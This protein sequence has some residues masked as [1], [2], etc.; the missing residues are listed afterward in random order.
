MNKSAMDLFAQA[1]KDY[2]HGDSAPLYFTVSN[3]RL[4]KEI[5]RYFRECYQL[6]NLEKKLISLAKGEVFDVGCATGYYFPCFENQPGVESVTGIDISPVLVD[7]AKQKGR[8]CFVGDIF[9]FQSKKKYDTITLLESNIGLGGNINKTK[10]LI[11]KLKQILKSD[12]QIL[13]YTS[14]ATGNNKFG[15]ADIRINYK[16]KTDRFRWIYFSPKFIQQLFR[17]Q[18]L[19]LAIIEETNNEYVGRAKLL[20]KVI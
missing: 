16:N 5:K 19:D 18:G 6:T 11:K 8:N 10:Q 13:F 12:G 14:K 9:T 15:I 17:D 4:T 2:Y 20:N 7:M 3:L 1:V